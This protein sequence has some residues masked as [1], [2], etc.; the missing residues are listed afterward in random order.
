MYDVFSDLRIVFES[1]F[2]ISIATA[3]EITM[4]NA[5]I[6]AHRK[7]FCPLEMEETKKI[8]IMHIRIGNL[9]LHGIKLFVAIAISFSLFE[10]IILLPTIPAALQPKLMQYVKDCLPHALNF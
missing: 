7:V 2:D 1:S 3:M 9:P 5:K 6:E 10:S 8:E 4:N